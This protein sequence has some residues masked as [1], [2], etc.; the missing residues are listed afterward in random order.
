MWS[1]RTLHMLLGLA[2]AALFAVVPS[3]SATAKV[4]GRAYFND[5]LV[6]SK[7][8]T[9]SKKIRSLIDTTP[10]RTKKSSGAVIRVAMYT[11]SSGE[12]ATIDALV[13]AAKRGV[14]VKLLLDS[15]NTLEPGST[16]YADYF[17][18]L[19]RKYPKFTVSFCPIGRGC[20]GNAHPG[21][22]N[23]NKF[24]LF[25]R[26]D[27]SARVVVQSSA[28]LNKTNSVAYWNNAVVLVNSGLYLDYLAYFNDLWAQQPSSHYGRIATSGSATAWHFPMIAGDPVAETLSSDV[29]CSGNTAV[30][31]KGRTIVRVAMKD[32]YRVE[33]AAALWY[34]ADRGCLV[35]VAYDEPAQFEPYRSQSAAV[36]A[37]L[38][39]PLTNPG[40]RIRLFVAGPATAAQPK[41]RLIHSKHLLIEGG[42]AGRKNTKVVFTGSHN[43]SYGSLRDNDET[44][45][46]VTSASIHDQYRANFQRILTT[47][48]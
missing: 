28:N 20:I 9:I 39:V 16:H 47:L 41:R 43:F 15:D 6:T 12:Q 4:T 5:P 13:R 7:Q 24:F 37:T 2:L 17:R 22:N 18:A 35:D 31:S 45:L 14:T 36:V 1:S 40:G 23:H 34:L 25:S 42:Y 44:L 21:S 10:G 32:F 19:A 48:A 38:Q 30:G 8:Y 33:V 3:P 46:R 11:Y 27:G 29:A 26:T